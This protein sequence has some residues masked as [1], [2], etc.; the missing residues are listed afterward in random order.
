MR[1][2]VVRGVWLRPCELGQQARQVGKVTG[3]ENVP[4][5][6]AESISD[7]HRRVIG[8]H[9]ASGGELGEGVARAP[10]RLG[11]LFRPQL[12]AVPDDDR[13]CATPGRQCRRAI[14]RHTSDGGEWTP[15]IDVGADRGAMMHKIEIHGRG[16]LVRHE[17]DDDRT[18][19]R[20]RM[21]PAALST[22][23]GLGTDRTFLDDRSHEALGQDGQEALRH[24]LDRGR[25]KLRRQGRGLPLGLIIVVRVFVAAFG[26]AAGLALFTRSGPALPMARVS[27]VLTG[28]T[29][30]FVYATSYFPSNRMP[31]DDRIAI[32]GTV[33]YALVWSAYLATSRRVR[34]TYV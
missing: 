18:R 7:P 24:H 12:S 13:M 6:A 5:F 16:I 2:E 33:V 22:A 30:T 14:D 34:N 9:I 1:W 25:E 28:L 17:W 8:L 4:W 32:A 27:L 31:G 11:G 3:K 26:L 20:G 15:R 10:E 21:A 23:C 29:N 19:R